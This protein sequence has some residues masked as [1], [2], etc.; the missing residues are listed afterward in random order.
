VLLYVLDPDADLGT[1]GNTVRLAQTA[2][3]AWVGPRCLGFTPNCCRPHHTTT[4]QDASGFS[5]QDLLLAAGLI[6]SNDR[7]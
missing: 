1:V 4:L 7:T 5:I 3:A 2:A 6:A